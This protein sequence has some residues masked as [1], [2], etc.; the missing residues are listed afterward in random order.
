VELGEVIGR[1]VQ[2]LQGITPGER[3]VTAGAT[4]IHDGAV[5]NIVP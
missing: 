3:V 2:V 1:S 4:I 5:L